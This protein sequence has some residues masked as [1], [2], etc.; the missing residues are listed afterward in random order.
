MA[1]LTVQ[2]NTRIARGMYWLYTNNE[3]QVEIERLKA[4]RDKT[5]WELH[6]AIV[7]MEDR[8]GDIRQ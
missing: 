2:K 7:A 6:L 8:L 3:L 4:S 1:N 5:D